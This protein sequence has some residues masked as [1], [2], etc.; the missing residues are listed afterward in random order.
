MEGAA[1]VP[2]GNLHNILECLREAQGCPG[3]PLWTCV[4]GSGVFS[5]LRW[6]LRASGVSIR[7]ILSLYIYVYGTYRRP[8]SDYT[9]STCVFMATR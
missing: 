9:G 8:I 2:Y 6:S 5:G 1:G 7:A 4:V 3:M